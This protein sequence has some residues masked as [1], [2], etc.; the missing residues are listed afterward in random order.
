MLQ[1]LNKK[2]ASYIF[3]FADRQLGHGDVEDLK[4][5]KQSGLWE[6]LYFQYLVFW[7]KNMQLCKPEELSHG[8]LLKVIY[9]K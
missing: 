7:V 1:G 8:A 6:N 4:K 2:K 5:R 9:L 3:S